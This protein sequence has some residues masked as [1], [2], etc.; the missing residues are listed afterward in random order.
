MQGRRGG[1]FG[2]LMWSFSGDVIANG[3]TPQRSLLYSEAEWGPLEGFRGAPSRCPGEAS[4]YP[5]QG[6][7][8]ESQRRL[9]QSS[10]QG[11]GW[12]EELE[13]DRL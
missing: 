11:R 9:P 7:G 3:C 2:L 6:G 13:S 5:G 1:G 8:E 12:E 4:L 10:V